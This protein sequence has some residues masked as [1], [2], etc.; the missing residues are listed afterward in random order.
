MPVL[1]RYDVVQLRDAIG[2]LVRREGLR[3]LAVRTGIPI[4]QIRSLVGGRAFRSGTLEQVAAALGLEIYIGPPLPDST[5]AV[6]LEITAALGLRG[7]ASVAEAVGVIDK[8]ELVSRLRAGLAAARKLSDEAAEAANALPLMISKGPARMRRADALSV[9]PFVTE[10]RFSPATGNALF[11]E[12]PETRIGIASGALAPWA[13]PERLKCIR[14]AATQA[15]T[16]SPQGRLAAIDTARTKPV[17]GEPFVLLA[18]SL[19]FLA[20]LRFRTRWI[21]DADTR[22]TGGSPLS[23]RH[24]ILGQVAWRESPAADPRGLRS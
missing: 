16:A 21:L 19:P 6:P 11:R 7:D 1:T 4:G 14:V 9:V 17:D 20:F 22:G 18:R 10:V 13:R 23:D 3:P 2:E 5:A 12:S 24:R 15:E 8:R